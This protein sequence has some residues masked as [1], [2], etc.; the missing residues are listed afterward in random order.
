MNNKLTNMIRF[1]LIAL[2]LVMFMTVAMQP[3][4][5]A[6][7]QKKSEKLQKKMTQVSGTTFIDVIVKPTAAWTS[8][9]T[10]DLNGKGATLKKAYSNFAFKVYRIKQSDINAISNR[11]DVDFMT[12]DDTVKTLGHLTATTGADSIRSL[13]GATNP[14]DGT[15]IGIVIVDSGVDNYS[16]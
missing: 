5:A 7:K 4:S 1:G 16:S 13:N 10:T 3:A 12:I 8:S 9:L 15:G 2:S 6:P 11:S 14:L